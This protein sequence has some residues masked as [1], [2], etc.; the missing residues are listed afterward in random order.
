M[1]LSVR[2]RR[3]LGDITRCFPSEFDD[4]T[5]DIGTLCLSIISTNDVAVSEMP[6]ASALWFVLVEL[7]F[8]VG[9]VGVDPLSTDKLSVLEITHVLLACLKHD[10]R[11]LAFFLTIYPVS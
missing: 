7:S 2:Y 3:R 10:V 4:I 6:L 1:F 11:A 5:F 8:E 9:T